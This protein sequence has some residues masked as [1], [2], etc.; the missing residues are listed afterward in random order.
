MDE[1][2]TEREYS[3]DEESEGLNRDEPATT[4]KSFWFN[5]GVPVVSALL[6]GSCLALAFPTFDIWPLIFISLT[7]PLLGT[8]KRSGKVLFLTGWLFM[9]CFYAL[10]FT[11]IVH[12]LR[13]FAYMSLPQAIGGLLVFAFSH[14]LMGGVW[15]YLVGKTRDLSG[16]SYWL[17]APLF[18]VPLEHFFP[19][20]F[21][22]Q[23]GCPLLHLRW[24]AQGADLGGAQVL[25]FLVSL[26]GGAFADLVVGLREERT[27]WSHRVGLA[28]LLGL[29][30]FLSGYG[31]FRVWQIDRVVSDAEARGRSL[32][33]GV[34]QPNIGIYEKEKKGGF[35]KHIDVLNDLSALVYQEGAQVIIWPETALQVHFDHD[36]VLE[37]IERSEQDKSW[38][39]LAEDLFLFNKAP[40]ITGGLT[41]R[42]TDDKL[43]FHNVALFINLRSKISG[44]AVKNHLVPFGEHLPK[45]D[46]IPWLRK[47]FR[48]AGN[49]SP[50][51][52]P[53]VIDVYGARMGLAICYEDI[54]ASFTRKLVQKDAHLIV[55]L[56]NDSWCGD[57]REP[58]QHLALAALRSIETRR[59]MVRATNT[60]VSALIDPTGKVLKTTPT[61]RRTI[62]VGSMPLLQGETLYVKCGPWPVYLCLL[63]VFLLFL[64]IIVEKI[65]T[66]RVS[67]S[68]EEIDN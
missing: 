22:W 2:A 65:R 7:I 62:M 21:S 15:L 54:I 67:P 42:E 19:V 52:E 47:R 6:G 30:L 16:L 10:G 20:L 26:A 1:Q 43:L 68:A 36:L 39:N 31:A 35:G 64:K 46:E 5:F 18:Y 32:K 13:V 33:I 23:I 41:E 57:G 11:W 4:R 53:S 61:F 28:V 45:E 3:S 9:A 24:V 17:L 55:N 59:A 34:V 51:H 44:M 38:A 29:V 8:H 12:T 40:L 14:G 25:T 37:E 49:I 56:T 50:G 27:G 48:H 66:K 60:G 58:Y 63:A